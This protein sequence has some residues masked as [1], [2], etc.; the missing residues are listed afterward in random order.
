[1]RGNHTD[2][3]DFGVTFDPDLLMECYLPWRD[4]KILPFSGGYL[5]QPPGVMK[6]LQFMDSMVAWWDKED[7]RPD[8]DEL[9]DFF[10]AYLQ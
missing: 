10:T 4:H 5:E 1:M 7:D 9:P 6:A 3:E 8:A 2:V